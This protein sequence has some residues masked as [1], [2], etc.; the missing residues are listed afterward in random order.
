MKDK[1]E[2]VM[3]DHQVYKDVEEAMKR[4]LE[5]QEAGLPAQEVERLRLIL[6]SQ[7]KAAHQYHS[8]A[9]GRA[10]LNRH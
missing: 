1:R 10:P 2:V 5:A 8:D 6:E 4:H 3:P 9:M 7:I